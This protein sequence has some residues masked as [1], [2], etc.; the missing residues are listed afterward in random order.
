MPGYGGRNLTRP[1]LTL[2]SIAVVVADQCTK[3]AA[4]RLLGLDGREVPIIPGLLWFHVIR[5]TGAAFGLFQSLGPLL[6]VMSIVLIYA[7]YKIARHEDDPGL[8]LSL[9]LILGGAGGN[10][11]D[12]IFRGGAVVDFIQ[13]P[14]WPIFN[15]ADCAITLGTAGILYFGV[16]RNRMKGE[17]E[18]NAPDSV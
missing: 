13:I 2:L 9:A 11:I 5:N 17:P 16:I 14:N 18:T 7:G 3:A 8:L 6:G 1:T 4:L 15:L 10:L 12:R